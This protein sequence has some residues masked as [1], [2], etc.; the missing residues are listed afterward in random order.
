MPEEAEKE[1]VLSRRLNKILETRFED[2]QVRKC[3]LLTCRSVFI[4]AFSIFI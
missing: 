3:L 4:S 2:D 1:N